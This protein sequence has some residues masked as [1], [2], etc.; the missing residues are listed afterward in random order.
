MT[1]NNNNKNGDAPAPE[2][3]PA[4]APQTPDQAQEPAAPTPTVSIADLTDRQLYTL[5]NS[6]PARQRGET[7]EQ[8]F[9]R[10]AL[11]NAALAEERRRQAMVERSGLHYA[12]ADDLIIPE[13]PAHILETLTGGPPPMPPGQDEAQRLRA[14]GKLDEAEE[15]AALHLY[16]ENAGIALE[17]LRAT[18]DFR[19][20][21]TL[22]DDGGWM[23]NAD[24]NSLAP[25]YQTALREQGWDAYQTLFQAEHTQFGELWAPN[26]E[27]ARLREEGIPESVFEEARQTGSLDAAL[28]RFHQEH[29]LL[30]DGTIALRADYTQFGEEFIHNDQLKAMMPQERNVLE[31]EGPAALREF[32]SGHLLVGGQWQAKTGFTLL[33]D[34]T[35]MSTEA[36][37][38][39]SYED[40]AYVQAHGYDAYLTD[41]LGIPQSVVDAGGEALSEFQEAHLWEPATASETETDGRWV[42]KDDFTSIDGQWWRN[43]QLARMS[44]EERNALETGGRKA[45]EEFHDAHLFEAAPDYFS[46]PMTRERRDGGCPR[47]TTPASTASG[48]A[49]RSWPT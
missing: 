18:R 25:H 31:A 32:L 7:N 42:A 24:F 16:G 27:I 12:D 41:K 5:A 10:V 15:V 22:L 36:L 40:Q 1:T 43:A 34:N 44:P 46:E 39:L 21:H 19:E 4:T 8:A 45:L 3:Q 9:A 11:I 48:G 14:E 26:S 29:L 2:A 30:E 35:W 49:T 20:A 33:A 37:Q 28:N 38:G 23:S 17:S 47:T 6:L 13:I